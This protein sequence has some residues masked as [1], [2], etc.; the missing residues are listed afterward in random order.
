MSNNS[1]YVS[2]DLLA[3]KGQRLLHHFI[4]LI[5]QYAVMYGLSYGFYYLGEFTG[6]YTLND[7]WNEMSG[8]EDLVV[9]YLLM[10]LYY[11]SMEKYSYKT[12]GKLVTNTMVVSFNGEVPTT[13]QI[14]KRSLSRWI[15]FDALSFLGANGKGWHDSIAQT[16]VVQAGKFNEKKDSVFELD[17]IG[18]IGQEL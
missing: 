16:Y 9:S 13:K 15:P 18:Q 3:S 6:N 5:P 17:Q 10:F 1:F 7:Y 4:D 8:F 14:L 2:K 11:F 12:L